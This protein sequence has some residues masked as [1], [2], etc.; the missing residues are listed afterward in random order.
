MG[1]GRV[2]WAW[3]VGMSGHRPA[4]PGV[5]PPV[6]PFAMP[7][8]SLLLRVRPFGLPGGHEAISSKAAGTPGLIACVAHGA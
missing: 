7:T 1:A 4:A 2:W 5:E 8:H 3:K 6:Y